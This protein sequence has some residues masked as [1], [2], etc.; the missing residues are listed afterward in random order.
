MDL[1]LHCAGSILGSACLG[2]M[3]PPDATRAFSSCR[4]ACPTMGSARRT[5][6]CLRR[7]AA[8]TALIHWPSPLPHQQY[9]LGVHQPAVLELGPL[10]ADRRGEADRDQGSQLW[11][12]H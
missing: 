4:S 9:L 10:P 3:L 11:L 7:R 1:I 12:L 5:A 6:C 8:I 2:A